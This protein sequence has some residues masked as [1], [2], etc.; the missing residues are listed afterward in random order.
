MSASV[1]EYLQ[2]QIKDEAEFI[3][4]FTYDHRGHDLPARDLKE[5]IDKNIASFLKTPKSDPRWIIVPGLRGVGKTTMMAQAYAGLLKNMDQRVNLLYISL[6]A[7]VDVLNSNLYETLNSYEQILGRSLVEIDKPTFLF[8][9]EIQAD[10]QWAVTLKMIYDK[11]SRV[12]MLCSGS[13]ATHLQMNADVAGRRA[14]IKKMYPMSFAEYQQLSRHQ[15]RLDQALRHKLIKGLYYAKNADDAH[16][17]LQTVASDV[18]QQ[19]TLYDRKGLLTYLQ[20]GSLPLALHGNERDIYEALRRMVDKIIDTDLR[21]LKHFDNSS[22]ATMKRLLFILAESG[23][24]VSLSKLAAAL[25]VNAPRIFNFLDVLVQA[26][27]LI[28]IPAYGNYLASSRKPA[29]YQFMSPAI[30]SLHYDLIGQKL[31]LSRRGALLE[32]LAGLHY[33]RDLVED[34]KGLLMHY[35][36]QK[37]TGH[38]DF[39]LV[40]TNGKKIAIEIGLGRKNTQQAEKTIQ[41]VKADYGIVFADTP[42]KLSAENVLLVPLDY[43]F[44]L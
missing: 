5:A 25:G 12:F 8:I 17:Q 41:K 35:Y 42:L 31:A 36:D 13:S 23:D 4:Q 21:S 14:A 34:A 1:L 19:W 2:N 26:E 15:P 43:F 30:R 20:T 16:R 37:Q 33:Q 10:K 32:D 22:L 18:N 3:R 24:T 40:M 44:L 38:C 28:K 6:D 9:D 11:T 29:R 7:V 27:L 39:V